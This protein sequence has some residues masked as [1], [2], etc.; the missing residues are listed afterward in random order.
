VPARR[1]RDNVD[2]PAPEPVLV[3]TTTASRD[4][5]GRLVTAAVEG[6]LAACAQISGPVHSEY[7]WEGTV[8]RASEWVCVFKTATDR[9]EALIET[10]SGLHS[11]DVPEIVAVPITAGHAGYL[12][13]I[14]AETRP[15]T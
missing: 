8:D 13:W 10:L 5:A 15:A 6:R 12:Q 14:L 9:V 3:T 7:W 2:V 11:Y 4:E 1:V